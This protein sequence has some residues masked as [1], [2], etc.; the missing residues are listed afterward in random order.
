MR[1]LNLSEKLRNI[2]LD[3]RTNGRTNRKRVVIAFSVVLALLLAIGYSKFPNLFTAKDAGVIGDIVGVKKMEVV[4][5]NDPDNSERDNI[6]HDTNSNV[7]QQQKHELLKTDIDPEW[8]SEIQQDLELA[9][10]AGT[11]EAIDLSQKIR[12]CQSS[13]RKLLL[14][15]KQSSQLKQ[16]SENGEIS[17]GV[18]ALD[19][20]LI[21]VDNQDRECQRYLVTPDGQDGF[22]SE[23]FLTA[24][25]KEARKGNA[26]AGFLYAMWA[27]SV[28]DNIS[29]GEKF[30][31]NFE[32]RAKDFT[33]YNR[34]DAPKLWLLALGFSYSTGENFTPSRPFLG[35]SYLIAAKICGVS[36]PL[37]DRQLAF[38]ELK[39]KALGTF[40]INT[41]Q[42]EQMAQ[43]IASENCL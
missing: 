6:G 12:D 26:V 9:L 29:L 38:T 37:V 7:E 13:R 27:P 35:S 23:F 32:Q 11:N 18:G 16:R 1:K 4:E 39:A 10:T 36:H 31:K 40:P 22:F 30:I 19:D 14:V 5:G 8:R 43:R 2:S 24:V 34:I 3:Q 25:E 17:I 21:F 33:S 42:L 28:E 41:L 15:D 20:M